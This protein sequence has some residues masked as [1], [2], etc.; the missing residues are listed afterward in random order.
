M[1]SIFHMAKEKIPEKI[2]ALAAENKL[3]ILVSGE[4]P[5]TS[6]SHIDDIEFVAVGTFDQITAYVKDFSDPELQFIAYEIAPKFKIEAKVAA[7]VT[8]YKK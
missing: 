6:E 3:Y 8:E 4:Y 5:I 7:E 1:H 2:Q